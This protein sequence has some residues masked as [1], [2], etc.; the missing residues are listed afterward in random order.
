MFPLF[1]SRVLICKIL[2]HDTSIGSVLSAVGIGDFRTHSQC[3]Y[4]PKKFLSHPFEAK[5]T[6]MDYPH[7]YHSIYHKM[8]I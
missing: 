4:F 2:K 7:S 1:G 5:K 8:Q 6:F 3:M